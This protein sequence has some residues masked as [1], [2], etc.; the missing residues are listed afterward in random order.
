MM[1]NRNVSVSVE[2]A[3]NALHLFADECDTYVASD[4]VHLAEVIEAHLGEKYEASTDESVEDSFRQIPDDAE[5]TIYWAGIPED[6]VLEE[7]IK[8]ESH[9][10]DDSTHKITALA[11]AWATSQGAGFLCSTEF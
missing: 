9:P 3:T 8:D 4:Y 5:V 10:G 11:R 6:L 1:N 2:L 7:A